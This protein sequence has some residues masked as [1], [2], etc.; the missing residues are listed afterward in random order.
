MASK[1]RAISAAA[2]TAFDAVVDPSVPTATVESIE[3]RASQTGAAKSTGLLWAAMSQE[4]VEALRKAYA[5]LSD[6][7]FDALVELTDPD[8]VFDF[9]RSIGPQKGIYRG[10][11]EIARFMAATEDAFEIFELSPIEFVV[12]SASRIVVRHHLRAKGRAS[13][14]EW[15]R[16]PP[17]ALVWELRDGKVIATTLYNTREEALE[18]AG[19][20]SA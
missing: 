19:A 8:W 15:E 13:G 12:G 1:R 3:G 4:N 14:L 2:S 11:G 17:V 10:H 7:D 16:V 5:A 9:S 20:P 18:A 6:R